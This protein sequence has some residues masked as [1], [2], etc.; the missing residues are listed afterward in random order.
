MVRLFHEIKVDW[1]GKRRI[2]IGLSIMLM[3]SG[4]GTALY[5]HRFH[6]NGTDAF[7]LG[8]D[9]KGGTVVTVRFKQPPTADAIRAAI[10]SVG[11]KGAVIQQ[12]LD[13]PG[14]S[15]IHLPRQGE[16]ESQ[17]G[18]EVARSRV[19]AALRTFGPEVESGKNLPDDPKAAYKIEGT[20]AV[21][22]VASKQ[23][24]TQAIAVTIAALVGMLLF[25]A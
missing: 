4:M 17:Q 24:R 1:L 10:D 15:L 21:G 22:E 5:R 2:F 9:F 8:V 11:L 19:N 23:L 25:I 20:E 14:E 18:V 3:L 13:R 16:V 7:N 6:P 12:T